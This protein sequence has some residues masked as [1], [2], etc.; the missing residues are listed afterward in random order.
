ML[1]K[2][3]LRLGAVAVAV[4]TATL[5]GA[6]SA[7][8]DPAPGVFKTLSGVGSDTTQDV[9]AGLATAVS[10][11]GSYDATGSAT[12]QT[13]AGGPSFV[14]PNGSGAGANAL[15]DSAQGGTHLFNSVDITGQVDF[16]RSS[17]GPSGSGTALTYIPFAKDAVTFAVNAASDFPRDIPIGSSS[18]D[19]TSPAP[20]TLRNVYR[21]SVTTF[22]DSNGLGV[23]IRPLLPQ[24]GSGTRKFWLATLGLTETDITAGGCATDLGNT[25]EEH[26]GTFIS[27][28]GD[29]AP[30]SVAQYI[31]QGNWQSLPSAVIERRGGI[32][33]GQVGGVKP[34]NI[35]TTGAVLNTGFPIV[36]NVY[37]IVQTSRLGD[38]AIAAAFV[39]T[40]SSVCSNAT[41]IKKYG[42]GTLGSLCGSTATTGPFTQ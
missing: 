19:S 15:S 27:G 1:K 12:I 39:G 33:L 14:R 38:A 37:N 29:I 23:T 10:S 40:S 26:N 31:A 28:P 6:I 24:S 20:F 13:K 17:S 35:T 16:A 7:S 34:Y 41:I 30:F 2:T 42:F 25:V 3:K 21:C 9:V 22:T 8:A 5:F 11:I 32:V 36:R 18:Q 4:C